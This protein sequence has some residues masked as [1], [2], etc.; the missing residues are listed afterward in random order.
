MRRGLGEIDVTFR[1]DVELP[2]FFCIYGHL[3]SPNL[4]QI[5]NAGGFVKIKP[6][7][8]A[9][10]CWIQPRTSVLK[11]ATGE[12]ATQISKTKNNYRNSLF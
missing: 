6:P 4:L 5:P 12:T 1:Q 2:L 7:C 9:W 11:T 10:S 3:N 8:L